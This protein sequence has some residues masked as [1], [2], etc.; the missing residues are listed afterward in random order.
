MAILGNIGNGFERLMRVREKQAQLS[1]HAYLATLDDATLTRVG[2]SRSELK[3][4][5][6]VNHFV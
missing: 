6:R 2:V 1:V 5:G 3:K 4:G